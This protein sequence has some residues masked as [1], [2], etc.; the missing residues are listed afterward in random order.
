MV[1]TSHSFLC[2]LPKEERPIQIAFSTVVCCLCKRVNIWLY[3]PPSGGHLY[4]RLDIIL[5]KGLTKHTQNTYFSGMKIEPKYAFFHAFF[6]I[7]TSC[8]YQ[9]L[10]LWPKTHPFFPILY[11]FAPLK[12]VRAY[13]AWSWKTTLITWFFLR[14]WYPTSNTSASLGTFHMLWQ[15]FTFTFFLPIFV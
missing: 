2:H 13:I 15:N 12:D 14:G 5:V 7:C 6:L 4:F 3:L 11:I 10:S 9:N 8:P 1:K